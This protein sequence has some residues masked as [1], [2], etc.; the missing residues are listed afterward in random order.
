MPF[1]AG[2]GYRKAIKYGTAFPGSNLTDFP[3]LFEIS[4]DTDIAAVLSGGG[5]V[6]LTLSDGTTTVPFG[7]Y[8]STALASGN[9][10]MRV[11]LSP[12]TAATTGDVMAYLYYDAGQSTS[13]DKANTVSNSYAL[14]MPFEEDPGGSAPQMFD[15][16]TNSN[17][18]TSSGSMTSSN[19]VAGEVA[20]CLSFNGSSQYITTTATGSIGSGDFT[21][22]AWWNRNVTSSTQDFTL[23]SDRDAG[24]DLFWGDQA[25]KILFYD[26][27]AFSGNTTLSGTGMWHYSAVKRSGTGMTQYYDGV[28]DGTATDSHTM[29]TGHAYRIAAEI[30]LSRYMNGK[31]DEVRISSAARSAD[32]IGYTYTDESANSSTFSLGAQETPPPPPPTGFVGVDEG[33]LYLTAVT[34]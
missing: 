1:L 18:G 34:W 10:T 33:I 3:K 21:L 12:L 4:G 27:T 26:G 28:A 15:W 31:I 8:P 25:D 5:G 6:T 29:P 32:W 14:F 16:V 30:G 11:K 7:L 17:I 9:I 23:I 20:N 22:E 24:G 19:L 2:W 13:E